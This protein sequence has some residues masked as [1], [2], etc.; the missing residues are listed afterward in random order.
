MD[1]IRGFTIVLER[2]EVMFR[3][4]RDV[5]VDKEIR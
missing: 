1:K 2:L 5:L 3:R 4:E